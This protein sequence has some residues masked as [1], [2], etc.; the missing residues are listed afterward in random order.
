MPHPLIFL[1]GYVRVAVG[2]EYAEAVVD[3]C[4]RHRKVYRNFTFHDEYVTLDVSAILARS[5]LSACEAEGIPARVESR[6]G[7]PALVYRYRRRYGAFL[8]AALF[9]FLALF[10]GQLLWDVRVEGNFRLSDAEVIGV[11]EESGL[12]VGAPLRSIETPAIET[13]A[14]IL[15]EDIAWISINLIGSVAEVHIIED[16][17]AQREDV[18]GY[19]IVAE[20]GGVIEWFEDTRGY[21]AAEIGQRVEAGDLLLGSE[22]PEEEGMP[23]RYA[24][25]KGK[26]WAR[27]EREF[28]V[29]VPFEYEKK[30]YT[31]REKCEKYFI[32][33]KKEV[34]FFGN[35]GN[36]YAECDTIDTVEYFELPGGVLLPFGVRTVKFLEYE[37]VTARRSEES[38]VELALYTLR[39]R[40]DSEVPEGMLTKKTLDGSFTDGGYELYCKA[41]YI[42]DIAKRE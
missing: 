12:S 4:R 3:L 6:H 24:T 34:K 42:E 36:L 14:L 29:S 5:F 25:P 18:L 37:T 19:D 13:R 10:S 20:R 32:F 28:S 11:L 21:Q 2:R 41:E 33:F 9:L 38:A 16:N 40:M 22:Y 7:L 23:T 39:C 26:V 8:G 31:G 1:F 30:E 17:G 35:S 15:S 27:T